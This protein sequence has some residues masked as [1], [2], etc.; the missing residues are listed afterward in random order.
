MKSALLTS[1]NENGS[2][3]NLLALW[4]KR[5][6]CPFLPFGAANGKHASPVRALENSAHTG[7]FWYL[8]IRSST[9]K[10]STIAGVAQF[11]GKGT[12][13]PKSGACGKSHLYACTLPN[14]SRKRRFPLLLS[15]LHTG[16]VWGRLMDTSV[17]QKYRLVLNARTPL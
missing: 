3:R 8:D 9:T 13:G 4:S 1:T 6:G 15:M 11:A 14:T 5:P 16:K 7:I 17:H 2:A 10:S 12:V